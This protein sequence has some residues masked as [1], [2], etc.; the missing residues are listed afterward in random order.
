MRPGITF[1]RYGVAVDPGLHVVR[2]DGSMMT[3]MFAAGMIM[4]ANVLPSGY[5]AGLGVCMS[6]VFGHRAGEAAAESCV[7]AAQTAGATTSTSGK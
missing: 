6:A 4:A 3:N 1:A 5:L 2:K 7:R